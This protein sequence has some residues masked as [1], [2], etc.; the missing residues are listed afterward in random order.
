[1]ED[2]KKEKEEVM[3]LFQ[4]VVEGYENKIKELEIENKEKDRQLEEIL[5]NMNRLLIFLYD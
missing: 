1:M 2:V 4:E 3:V 5:E